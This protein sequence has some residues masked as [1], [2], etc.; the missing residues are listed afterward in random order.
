MNIEEITKDFKDRADLEKFAESQYSLIV[1]LSKKINKLEEEKLSLKRELD[2]K[3]LVI[4]S[5]NVKEL[6]K[7][8][9]ITSDA[10]SICVMQLSLL[11][12]ISLDRELTLEE[13]KKTEIYTKVLNSLKEKDAGKTIDPNI[14]TKDLL[15]LVED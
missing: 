7:K 3:G 12:D 8:L 1:E 14:A 13:C 11:R 15:T 5:N 6:E 4:N 10:E 2:N 9:S